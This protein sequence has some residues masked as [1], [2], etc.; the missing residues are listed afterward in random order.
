[1]SEADETMST[2]LRVEGMAEKYYNEPSVEDFKH[3]RTEGV[4]QSMSF[5][6]TSIQA[7]RMK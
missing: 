1:M 7:V 6:E 2:E 5:L 3:E 4:R